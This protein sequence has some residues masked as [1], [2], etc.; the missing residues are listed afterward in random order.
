M[1]YLAISIKEKLKAMMKDFVKT[2][3]DIVQ[4]RYW[5][6]IPLKSAFQAL[7]HL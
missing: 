3:Y 2:K 4:Q 6:K 1:S 7:R 5:L